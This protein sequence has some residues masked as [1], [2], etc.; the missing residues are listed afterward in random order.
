[1]PYLPKRTKNRAKEP[2][3]KSTNQA[4]YNSTQWRT[5][6]VKFIQQNPLCVVHDA[7]NQIVP[8]TVVDHCIPITQ[9]GATL[10]VSNLQ[11]LCA[12]CHNRKSAIE[13]HLVVEKA[14]TAFGYIPTDAGKKY[15]IDQLT[16][17]I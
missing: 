3:G 1:M 12:D 2:W 16:R 6:R 9:G 7:V 14:S 17:F 8:A 5:L 10:S 4:F 15:I 11:S 13:P